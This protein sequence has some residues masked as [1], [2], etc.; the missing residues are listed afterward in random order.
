[1]R[2]DKWPMD[3][4]MQLPDWCYG[5]RWQISLYA[6]GVSG[7]EAWDIT[8]QGLPEDCILWEWALSTTNAWGNSDRWRIALGDQLPTTTAMMDHNEPLI[9]GFG[10][11]GGEPREIIGPNYTPLAMRRL[12]Q[13]I[14][15]AGMRPI[16]EVNP[17]GSG[18]RDLMVLMTFSS[19]PKEVPDWLISGQGQNLL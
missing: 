7:A 5:R 12:R 16:L 11:Q 17:N 14:H 10:V 19:I 9:H 8:E 6:N 2:L 1:M 4:I 3:K 13:H 18:T 15:S